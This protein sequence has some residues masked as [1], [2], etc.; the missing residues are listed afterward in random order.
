MLRYRH[1]DCHEFLG[2]VPTYHYSAPHKS[3]VIDFLQV[4]SPP[5]DPTLLDVPLIRL[6]EEQE[7]AKRRR[8]KNLITATSTELPSISPSAPFVDQSSETVI[9]LA[10]TATPHTVSR[11]VGKRAWLADPLVKLEAELNAEHAS[12]KIEP[13]LAWESKLKCQGNPIP[14]NA[15]VKGDKEHLLAFDLS[16]SLLLPEDMV[17]TE[18]MPDIQIIKSTVKSINRVRILKRFSEY[19]LG[20]FLARANRSLFCYRPSKKYISSWAALLTY[21]RR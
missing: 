12:T 9:A 3:K 21:G 4:P 11:R 6:T 15:L 7:M 20:L 5:P 18:H 19:L 2:Y 17:G 1:R 13:F 8:I 14:V 16:K 10:S